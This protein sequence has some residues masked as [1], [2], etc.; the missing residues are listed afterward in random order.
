LSDPFLT[1]GLEPR[2]DVDLPE[3]EA[4]HRELSRA[5]HPDRYV[6]RPS[7]ERRLALSRAIEVNEALR[8]LRHPVRRAE[9]LLARRG[10]ELAEG[11]EP[12]PSEDLLMEVLE[13]REE[14]AS[15]RES[16]DLAR[17]EELAGAVETREARVL[18]EL[19]R[20][21]EA[22]DRD[23]IDTPAEAVARIGEQLGELRYYERF[24]EEVRAI[25][26]ELG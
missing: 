26:D 21:F 17:V 8:I 24:L 6:G 13:L 7:A 16:G 15:A 3:L 2:F 5:L 23:P 11:E 4:R 18:Q 25:E 10:V 20:A 12:E 14:L 1:L 19:S 9:A 22:L